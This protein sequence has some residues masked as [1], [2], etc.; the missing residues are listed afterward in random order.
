MEYK[1]NNVL[2]Y[3]KYYLDGYEL[4]QYP[5]NTTKELTSLGGE[6]VVVKDRNNVVKTYYVHTDQL[7]SLQCLTDE[8]GDIVPNAEFSFDPWGKI[9]KKDDW[10]QNYSNESQLST[11]DIIGRGFTGHEHMP[12]FGLINM[13]GRV[14]DPMLGQFIQPDNNIQFPSYSQNYNRYSYC[15]NN[16]V[17]FTDPSGEDLGPVLTSI[18]TGG[19]YN[20]S[21]S[22]SRIYNAYHNF[23]NDAGNEVLFQ[24][25]FW[26]GY[27][28]IAGMMLG[29]SLDFLIS[30]FANPGISSKAN[31]VAS[32]ISP[33]NPPGGYVST[34]QGLLSTINFGPGASVSNAAS[35]IAPRLALST[36]GKIGAAAGAVI[37]AW[38]VTKSW[39]AQYIA[40]YRSFASR[41]AK[42]Y[43]VA[44]TP[45][46]CEDLVLQILIDFASQNQ[47][48]VVLNIN[49]ITYNAADSRW[50]GDIKEFRDELFNITASSHLQNSDNTVGIGYDDLLPGD[51]LLQVLYP[52]G[53]SNHAQE[54][55][56]V[57]KY[58]IEI[59]QGNTKSSYFGSG[60]PSQSNYIGTPLNNSYFNRANGNFFSGRTRTLEKFNK[61]KQFQGKRW[62]FDKFNKWR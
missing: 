42:E 49:G 51:M 5:D 59:I 28:T 62:N 22:V 4:I 60:K 57:N 10:T 2:L 34:D 58:F 33:N 46:T 17:N 15:L 16:P 12:Q 29:Q 9:R 37:G 24:T 41:R 31:D 48:P 23:G 11:F 44:G 3:T 50:G 20:I 54:V 7:G 32:A 55:V 25:I 13:N 52:N 8:N 47:L 26:T 1:E 56:D 61:L 53:V 40:S 18:L 43:Q 27:S 30:S 39:N 36:G 21:H 45:F 6:A 19:G 35:N 14:Y 38:A